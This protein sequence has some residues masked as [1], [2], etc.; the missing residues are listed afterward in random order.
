MP[1]A[2]SAAKQ[3]QSRVVCV[4]VCVFVS[5]RC[6][7]ARCSPCM[8][9]GWLWLWR[10][11]Q[12]DHGQFVC[13]SLKQRASQ[14]MCCV[15]RFAFSMHCTAHN[16]SWLQRRHTGHS[17]DLG[18]TASGRRGS[19]TA[20]DQVTP[21]PTTVELLLPVLE[22]NSAWL[23]PSDSRCRACCDPAGSGALTLSADRVEC[24]CLL[25]R[26]LPGSIASFSRKSAH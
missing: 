18:L 16:S 1:A 6:C 24:T 11:I 10:P 14:C 2:A 9:A 26:R 13:S 8:T 4:C 12:H 23:T 5:C 3:Q 20:G 7:V 21:P 25:Q 17:S 19:S 15:V 22:R